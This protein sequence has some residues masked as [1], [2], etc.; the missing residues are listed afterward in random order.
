MILY[1]YTVVRLSHFEP[2]IALRYGLLNSA[3]DFFRIGHR[4]IRSRSVDL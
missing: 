2:E 1:P 4:T 3:V